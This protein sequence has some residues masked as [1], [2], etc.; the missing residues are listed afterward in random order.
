MGRINVR[1]R[2]LE[3]GICAICKVM[4]VTRQQGL[5][6]NPSWRREGVERQNPSH[7]TLARDKEGGSY[8]QRIHTE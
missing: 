1:K 7:E 6:L 4:V 2:T 5:Y 8:R 3:K